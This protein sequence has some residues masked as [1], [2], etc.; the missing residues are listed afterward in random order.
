MTL[1]IATTGEQA[2]DYARRL[3]DEAGN[4]AHLVQTQTNV[5]EGVVGFEV[6]AELARAAGFDPGDDEDDD[7]AP[8]EEEEDADEA[9]Q[10]PEAPARNASRAVWAD[11]LDQQDPPL[12][13]DADAS[14]DDLIAV[15]DAQTT[16]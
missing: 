10:K 3:L 9:E 16:R 6:P 4:D 7:T 5:G 1:I 14:R 13:Y 15:W 12:T 2:R 11:W 8:A